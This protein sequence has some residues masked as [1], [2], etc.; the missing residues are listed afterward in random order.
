MK[1]GNALVFNI[2]NNKLAQGIVKV[3]SIENG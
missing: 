1:S 3:K 2:M